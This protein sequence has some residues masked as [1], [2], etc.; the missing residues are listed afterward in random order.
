MNL[1]TAWLKCE[2]GDF[3]GG[4]SED[5]PRAE[6]LRAKR[7]ERGRST[8]IESNAI[9]KISSRNELYGKFWYVTGEVGEQRKKKLDW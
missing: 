8:K 3:N 6:R 2:N 1:Q 9:R 5:D 4:V 7:N